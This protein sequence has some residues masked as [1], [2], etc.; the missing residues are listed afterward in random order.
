[1]VD[2]HSL[3]RRFLIPACNYTNMSKEASLVFSHQENCD[4]R[5]GLIIRLHKSKQKYTYFCL[6]TQHPT[7]KFNKFLYNV[8]YEQQR[9][10]S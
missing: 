5:L 9:G 2:Y 6:K 4:P 1:M 7:F 8:G 3:R 10:I